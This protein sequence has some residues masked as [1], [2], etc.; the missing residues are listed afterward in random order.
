MVVPESSSGTFVRAPY[1]MEDMM[2]DKV[3]LT[4]T[5]EQAISISALLNSG[6][7]IGA[8]NG[9]HL[10]GLSSRLIEE[11]GV[12]KFASPVQ[13]FHVPCGLGYAIIPVGSGEDIYIDVT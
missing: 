9:L 6:C 3:F 11:L 1:V 13:N 8:V 4:L 12:H 2:S 10:T 5:R 7:S